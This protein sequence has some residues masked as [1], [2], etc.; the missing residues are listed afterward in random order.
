[1]KCIL[2]TLVRL[3]F[4]LLM[5]GKLTIGKMMSSRIVFETILINSDIED[6]NLIQIFDLVQGY[7]V[8]RLR[9][10]LQILHGRHHELVDRP[11]TSLFQMTMDLFTKRFSF[12]YLRQGLYRT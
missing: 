12:L 9:S 5:N 4:L 11:E 3:I 2:H 8:P 1:M 6:L 7:V 10:S